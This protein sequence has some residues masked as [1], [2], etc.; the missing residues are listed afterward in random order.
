MTPLCS[1][2]LRRVRAATSPSPIAYSVP[3]V[4][5]LKWAPNPT[6][7]FK[8]CHRNCAIHDTR[9]SGIARVGGR[10]PHGRRYGFQYYDAKHGRAH[11]HPPGNRARPYQKEMDAP[12]IDALRNISL[13]NIVATGAGT[14]G[15]S[16]TGLPGHPVENIV[17]RDV[18]IEFAGGGTEEDA[19]RVP[20]ELPD[21]Y[22]EYKMFGTLPAYGFYSVTPRTSEW[23]VF[24]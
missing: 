10:R 20:D 21:K 5:P 3:T 22:P 16:I 11:F 13:S 1:R 14:V 19:K 24:P 18:R 4:M 2:A 15:C 12:G 7:A 17:L 9:L 23:T 6:A 8:H